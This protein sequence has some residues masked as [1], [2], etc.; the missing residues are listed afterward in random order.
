M[1]PHLNVCES[2]AVVGIFIIKPS[3]QS[4]ILAA[5]TEENPFGGA[6]Q[7]TDFDDEE[8]EIETDDATLPGGGYV[9]GKLWK[10]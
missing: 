10:D 6:K 9:A 3:S 4:S 8:E 5:S 7:F 1:T 2:K